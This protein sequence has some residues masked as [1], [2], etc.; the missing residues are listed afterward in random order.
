[1]QWFGSL[2]PRIQAFLPA[3]TILEIAPGFGRWTQFLINHCENLILV[4]LSEECI[5]ACQLR[6]SAYNNITYFTNDG[7]SL[8]MVP[9]NSVDF[10]FTFD[11][12]VH[13]EDSIISSYIYQFSR[14]LTK[15]G[16]AFIHHSNLGEY[17]GY[18]RLQ[19]IISK[20][21]K[22]LPLLSKLG[23]LDNVLRDWRAKSMTSEKM[24]LFANENGMRCI[25]QEKIPWST[26]NTLIDCISTIAKKDSIW[27]RENIQLNNFLFK[28]EMKNLFNLSQLY[29]LKPK[30]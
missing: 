20:I 12:L 9:D 27:S 23:I 10:I 6:F 13:A 3:S 21:P 5:K 24:M 25:S 28:K 16:V 14:K 17:P 1:M 7:S 26:N 11:S 15:N 30:K 19:L 22:L 2:L 8:D 18:R 29:D 4:D